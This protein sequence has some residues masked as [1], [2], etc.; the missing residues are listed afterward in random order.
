MKPLGLG[1]EAVAQKLAE[2]EP[3]L[4]IA[5]L[6]RD[7][8]S[9]PA[10]LR[11][12]LRQIAELE[13]D[14]VVGTQ[15]IT[16]GHHFPRISLVGVLLADQALA[17]P[18]F[19]AAERAFILLT[20][21]AGRA[22]REEQAGAGHRADLRPGAPR[23]TGGLGQPAPGLLRPGTGP[24]A[25]PLAI[26]PLHRLISLR[27]ESAHEQA[28]ARFRRESG[29]ASGHGPP[30]PGP[31]GPGIGARARANGQGPGK[32]QASDTHQ[33]PGPRRGRAG[34]APGP[35]PSWKNPGQACG[36]S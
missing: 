20:Q 16:K 12:L 29:P 32:V 33:G 1:T 24:S 17:L 23:R 35:A 8:A 9:N 11:R 31:Q 27:V 6:D 25:R 7:T 30:P 15:M 22:G 34:F 36:L 10:K 3:E 14:V 19:G 5:R 13:V 2:M 28:A 26:R 4:R 21:V 18:D